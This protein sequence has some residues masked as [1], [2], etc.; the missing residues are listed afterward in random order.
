MFAWFSMSPKKK[1]PTE[2][3]PQATSGANPADPARLT[4]AQLQE[5]SYVLKEIS[6]NKWIVRAVLAAGLAAVLE[7][8][9]LSW[10]FAKW[11]YYLLR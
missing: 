9:H 1:S 10:L 6:D 2:P 3:E 8:A 5:W 4:P 11:L 7:V